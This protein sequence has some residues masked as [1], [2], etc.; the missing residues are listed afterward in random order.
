MCDSLGLG[1]SGLFSSEI[2]T[3]ADQLPLARRDEDLDAEVDPDCSSS[4]GQQV[5]RHLDTAN[6]DAPVTPLALH[7]DCLGDP[8]YRPVELH[9]HRSDAPEL[10][11][12]RLLVELPARSVFPLHRVK[13]ALALKARV[14]GLF[15]PLAAAIKRTKGTVQSP[16]CPP[17]DRHPKEE[18]VW[19]GRSQFGEHPAVIEVA[20]R[21]LLPAPGSA[22]LPPRRRC[23][24]RVGPPRAASARSVDE[25]SGRGGTRRC[26]NHSVT[27]R[28]KVLRGYI[29]GCA[30][31]RR[32]ERSAGHWCRAGLRC[33]CE[34]LLSAPA[35]GLQMASRFGPVSSIRICLRSRRQ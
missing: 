24:A 2:S 17:T 9:L 11:P 34:Q 21:P 33:R 15:S 13:T 30:A 12:T 20:D 32:L 23:T 31:S 4:R 27:R 22:F 14:A 25:P 28:R 3:G 8:S 5:L 26:D 35:H 18:D 19:S 29:N 1:Q 10:Q 16:Q 6:R 7:R